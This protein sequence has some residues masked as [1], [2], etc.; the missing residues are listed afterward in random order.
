MKNSKE[1]WR[2][3]ALPTGWPPRTWSEADKAAWDEHRKRPAILE[4]ELKT[5]SNRW[6][7]RDWITQDEVARSMPSNHVGRVH[8]ARR[9]Q[10]AGLAKRNLG[11]L[12]PS[13]ANEYMRRRYKNVH[14]MFYPTRLEKV[15]LRGRLGEI[16]SRAQRAL[17]R[18]VLPIVNF[19]RQYTGKYV[20]EKLPN[21]SIRP[22]PAHKVPL[23]VLK[24]LFGTVG[25]VKDARKRSRMKEINYI[26]SSGYPSNSDQLI[27]EEAQLKENLRR[28]KP[29]KRP[30]R[31]MN[32]R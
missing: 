3:P 21:G 15:A 12:A 22:L 28:K 16:N 4:L 31:G 9:A 24:T 1:I 6:L 7:L 2:L 17:L 20:T 10:S 18:G 14:N 32:T 30:V 29:R 13:N 26:L 27:A 11:N 5:G 19:K 25:V 8:S 23:P